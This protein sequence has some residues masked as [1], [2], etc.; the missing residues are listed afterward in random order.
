MPTEPNLDEILARWRKRATQLSASMRF[1]PALANEAASVVQHAFGADWLA[2]RAVVR[3]SGDAWGNRAHEI[4]TALA[5]ADASGVALVLEMSAYLKFLAPLPSYASVIAGLKEDFRT[6][7]LQLS[8]AYRVEKLGSARVVL[9]PPVQDGR[10]GD[11]GFNLAGE[12]FVAECYVQRAS[13]WSTSKE[14]MWLCRRIPK[15]LEQHG[16]HCVAIAIHLKKPLDARIRKELLRAVERLLMSLARTSGATGLEA[17]NS[18]TV[19]VM[20][21]VPN[22]EF[23]VH[24]EFPRDLGEPLMGMNQR[25]M[26]RAHVLDVVANPAVPL[27][28]SSPVETRLVIW[29]EDSDEAEH[30]ISRDLNRPLSRLA[31]RLRTKTAQTR[32]PGVGRVL[33]CESWVADQLKRATPEQLRRFKAELFGPS[34]F[35]GALLFVGRSWDERA[36]RHRCAFTPLQSSP[37]DPRCENL[38]GALVEAERVTFIP[39]AGT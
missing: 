24:P 23:F 29:A 32:S 30:S 19:S 18:W 16:R 34:G 28:P 12:E 20:P 17:T 25:S 5:R 35:I 7:L 27:R 39:S 11:V 4:G 3:D 10:L 15:L 8:F 2:R 37:A 22:G 21:T 26:S 13:P 38:I 36:F 14:G 31:K 1:D 9:E 6:T 33:L